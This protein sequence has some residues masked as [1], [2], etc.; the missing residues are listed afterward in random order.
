MIIIAPND[1]A[2]QNK[3]QIDTVLSVAAV[4]TIQTKLKR[5][6]HVVAVLTDDPGDD[7]MSASAVVNASDPSKIDV[8]TWKNTGGTDPT[9]VA[10]TTFGKR[11]TYTAYGV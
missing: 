10:A 1:L 3:I 11:V 9:P 7:P 2:N 5:V 8:K 4:D 6:D